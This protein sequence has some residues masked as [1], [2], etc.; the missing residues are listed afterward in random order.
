MT[1][2]V[3]NIDVTRTFIDQIFTQ[4]EALEKAR[5][6]VS[7]GLAVSSPSDDPAR[8][9]TIAEF[10]STISRL[11]KHQQ[12]IVSAKTNLETQESILSQTNDIL[13]QAKELATQAASSTI[14]PESRKQMADQ[15]FQLRDTLVGLANTKYQG[16]YIYGGL[17]TSTPPYQTGNTYTNPAVPVTD[18]AH[19]RYVYNTNA[20]ADGTRDVQISD[21][22]SV[23][24]N[25]PGSV[26][27][28]AIS[29][30]EV[31]GRAL[32]GYSSTTTAGLPDGGGTAYVFPQDTGLQA[33]AI[34]KSIDALD[35]ARTND[36]A[37]ELTSVGSRLNRVSQADEIVSVVKT[38]TQEANSS[39]Q[40]ADIFEAASRL[41]NLE[42][43][44]Q[45]LLASGAK[46]NS[47]SLLNY[48]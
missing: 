2:R 48:I 23:Q 5:Q 47:L 28:N 13:V 21:S 32:K 10:Q 18:S 1:F 16:M 35:N 38:N 17:D 37:V 41:T 33:D 22:D 44:L 43:S 30:L 27:Q 45:G 25:T 34:V 20:G 26:F 3:T 12:R 11:E 29:S 31:L 4:R 14:T 24:I 19:I 40:D 36:I 9:A 8:A 6:Q 46:I 42:T 15:I 39:I 7:S